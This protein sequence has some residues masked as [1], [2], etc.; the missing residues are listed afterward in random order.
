MLGRS[1][2]EAASFIRQ[3]R[4]DD[5]TGPVDNIQSTNTGAACCRARVNL[6]SRCGRSG[7]TDVRF[8][9]LA[10]INA[11]SEDVRFRG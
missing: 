4:A 5:A 9:H 11:A 10:D 8:W 6:R 7:A 1:R 2:T 3:L